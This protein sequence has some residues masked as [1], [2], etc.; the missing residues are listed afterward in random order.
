ME[1]YIAVDSGKFASNVAEYKAEKNSVRT[2]SIRTKVSEGDF[3]DD[4]IE[5]NTVIVKI[6][7]KVYKV[8]NGAK[9]LGAELETTK[10]TDIHRIC[11][12]AALA[13][14]ASAKEVD[15]INVA[16]GLP[17]T[18]WENVST[19]MDYKDFILPKGEVTVEFKKDSASDV[20]KKTFRIKNR[21]VFPESY[22]ALAQDGVLETI[23]PTSITG[24]IDIG[25]LNLNATLWQGTELISDKST[26]ANLGG[27]LLIQQL[28]QEISANITPC[29]ELITANILKSDDRAIPSGAGASKEQIDKSRELIKKVLKEHAGKV[30]NVCL[31]KDWSLNVTRLIAIGGTSKDLADELSE[32]FG[33]ITVLP[34][35]TFCNALGYLRMMCAR[36]PG[37]KAI[38]PLHEVP[39]I[40]KTKKDD[41]KEEKSA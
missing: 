25:N 10:K 12:L 39:A 35:A 27:A 3:R 36:E 2:F 11:V 31:A 7:G 41:K 8:G 30:K 21:Y 40:N 24:V 37:V 38:I 26:T 17:A 5:E 4:A 34:D 6:D 15:D 19:R 20:V 33:N 16:V 18:D 28:S 29:N 23:T 22:G 14:V 32:V 1:R 9:G 13:T